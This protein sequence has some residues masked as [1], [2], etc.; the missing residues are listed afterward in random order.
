MQGL[1]RRLRD[2][3]GH[4]FVT[5]ADTDYYAKFSGRLGDV[6]RDTQG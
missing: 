1:V 4:L 6:V 2:K 3:Y 5:D